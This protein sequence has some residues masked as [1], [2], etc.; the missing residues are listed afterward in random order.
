MYHGALRAILR[1]L[2]C[3]ICNFVIFVWDAAAHIGHAYA[4]NGLTID[5]YIRS[6][7]LIG[8]VELYLIKG[9]KIFNRV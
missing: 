7:H 6:E 4:I 1:N 2:F 5:V 8:S 9:Y 3:I